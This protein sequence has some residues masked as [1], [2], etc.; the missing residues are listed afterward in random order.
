MFEKQL[1]DK[2]EH[3]NYFVQM[4]N[5]KMNGTFPLLSDDPSTIYDQAF[6]EISMGYSSLCIY[7]RMAI[8]Q[9][10]QEFIVPKV[11]EY[12]PKYFENMVFVQQHAG[13]EYV[14]FSAFEPLMQYKTL[15]EAIAAG[16]ELLKKKQQL[17]PGQVFTIVCAAFLESHQ[18]H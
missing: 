7:E 5:R 13:S 4:T 10:D 18:W 8:L 3:R 17:F 9:E 6:K 1:I 11:R 16:K 14:A 2:Q 15:D 12:R